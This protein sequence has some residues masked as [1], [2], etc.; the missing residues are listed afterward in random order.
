MEIHLPEGALE[1]AVG[2][3]I[4]ATLMQ[5]A[6]EH[7]V[8]ELTPDLLRKFATDILD[9]GLKRLNSWDLRD[10]VMATAKP[11]IK[12]YSLRPDFIAQ[13]EE[14]VNAG[15]KKFIQDLPQIIYDDFKE[16]VVQAIGRKYRNERY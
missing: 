16:T 5:G 3:G 2:K 8:K 15:M 12:E 11:M 10:M 4:R 1:D 6:V 13:V 14:A 9:E 7:I